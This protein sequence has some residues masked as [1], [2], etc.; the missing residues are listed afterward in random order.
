M[1]LE[2]ADIRY[3]TP[4][5]TLDTYAYTQAHAHAQPHTCILIHFSRR[6]PLSLCL[7]LSLSLYHAHARALSL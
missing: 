4:P 3:I 1:F 2:F 5:Y 6:P 7:S